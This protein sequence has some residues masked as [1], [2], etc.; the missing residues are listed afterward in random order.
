[1]GGFWLYRI[2]HLIIYTINQ[3][4]WTLMNHT[5]YDLRWFCFPNSLV[6]RCGFSYR[7]YLQILNKYKYLSRVE[8]E[9]GQNNLLCGL[10]G[11]IDLFAAKVP[12]ETSINASDALSRRNKP[13][14]M[15]E[16]Q[17]NGENPKLK[18]ANAKYDSNG[19]M[20]TRRAP[21]SDGRTHDN[22]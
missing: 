21:Y 8:L 17:K 12:V 19:I 9:K 14:G 15:D 2:S 22:Y 20:R 11:T 16:Q 4:L 5:W 6:F 13:N 3:P 18:K 10:R 1:M 7:K